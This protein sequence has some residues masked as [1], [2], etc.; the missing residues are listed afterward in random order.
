M[1]S[2][3][4]YGECRDSRDREVKIENEWVEW[5]M[6]L[7]EQ[8]AYEETDPRPGK[9][10]D[11]HNDDY[12]TGQPRDPSFIGPAVQGG[13]PPQSDASSPESGA[14]IGPHPP[15][16]PATMAGNGLIIIQRETEEL[17]NCLAPNPVI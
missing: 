17:Q 15:H 9:D 12:D 16:S 2:A 6:R 11:D 1:E 4:P 8:Q 14:P 13:A 7:A 3:D 10:D 5:Q